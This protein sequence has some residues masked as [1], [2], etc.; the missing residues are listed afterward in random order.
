[1]RARARDFI[2]EALISVGTGSLSERFIEA[3]NKVLTEEICGH[4]I[5]DRQLVPITDEI[6]IAEIDAILESAFPQ[7]K[8]H[9]SKALAHFSDRT[10]PDYPNSIKESI[11]AVESICQLIIGDRN[12]SLGRALNR[13]ESEGVDLNQDLKEGLQKLYG[14]TNTEDGIRHAMMELSSVDQDDARFMLITCSAFVNYLITEA[15]KAGIDLQAN[16]ETIARA[17][18]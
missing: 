17:R 2:E 5:V 11:S 16:Y 4:R 15:S 3:C 8:S 14:Y 10:I 6:E 7:L 1:M 9:I 18:E 12:A 13:L